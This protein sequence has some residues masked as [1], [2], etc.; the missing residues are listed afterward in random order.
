MPHSVVVNEDGMVQPPD[1]AS[2][3]RGRARLRQKLLSGFNGRPDDQLEL[4]ER[5]LALS[6]NWSS[7]ISENSVKNEEIANNASN[8]IMARRNKSNE[9]SVPSGAMNFTEIEIPD[10]QNRAEIRHLMKESA[11]HFTEAQSQS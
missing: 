3:K 5:L 6:N 2:P 11:L 1:Y 4:A 7:Q 10:E 9:V 8:V